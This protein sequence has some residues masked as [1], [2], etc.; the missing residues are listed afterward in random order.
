MRLINRVAT[1]AV[2]VMAL[3]F[4]VQAAHA[5]TDGQL[6]KSPDSPAI[7]QV[8]S[9]KLRPF[10]NSRVFKTYYAN[11][12]A[13]KV[14]NLSGHA[15]DIPMRPR[16]GVLM[17]KFPYNP[18]VYTVGENGLLRHIP[19]EKTAQALFGKKWNTFI[20]ELPEEL[21][22]HYTYGDELEEQTPVEEDTAVKDD[23]STD[24]KDT[25]SFSRKNFL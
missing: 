14:M 17:L 16:A 2:M 10:L 8:V 4:G 5:L 3:F 12:D 6:V 9:G 24:S 21:S 23:T 1:S 25:L 19:N 20:I 15:V 22:V 18:K 13:V 7:Y 11:F